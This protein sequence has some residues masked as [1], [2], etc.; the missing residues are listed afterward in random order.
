LAPVDP[1]ETFP[2]LQLPEEGL[3]KVVGLHGPSHHPR[4]PWGDIFL[5]PTTDRVDSTNISFTGE[6]PNA[7]AHGNHPAPNSQGQE[8]L[9]ALHHQP[10]AKAKSVR[11]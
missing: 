5:R 11:G 10:H 6:H 2:A 3:V 4:Y 8:D 7:R 9:G 1:G